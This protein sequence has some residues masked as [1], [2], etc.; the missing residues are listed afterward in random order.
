MAAGG[1]VAQGR[2]LE[3]VELRA[4]QERKW[5]T[6]TVLQPGVA[7]VL[8]ARGV[9]DP[10][11]TEP[12]GVD[13]LWCFKLERCRT[14]ELWQQLRIDGS[15][16]LDL[17]RLRHGAAYEMPLSQ[18]HAYRVPVVGQGRPLALWL[19]DAMENRSAN[20]NSGAITVSL[21]EPAAPPAGAAASGLPASR[22]PAGPVA[23]AP[24]APAVPAT[25]V[26]VVSPRPAPA[27]TARPGPALAAAWVG[28]DRDEVGPGA[29]A[30][31]NGHADGHFRLELDPGN[32]VRTV[33]YMALHAVDADG[34]P[35]GAQVWDTTPNGYWILGV[36]SRDRRLNPRDGE[37]ADQVWSPVSYDLFA[38]NSG[39]FNP[40]QSFRLLVRFT[41]GGELTA[42]ARIPP[43]TAAV[44][45]Q[46]PA[47]PAMTSPAAVAAAPA[48]PPARLGLLFVGIDRDVVGPARQPVPNGQADG[49]FRITVDT[50]GLERTLNEI[51]LEA[52]DGGGQAWGS[53]P[54]G[55]SILAVERDGRRL[56]PSD[57]GIAERIRGRVAYDVYGSDAGSFRLGQ[58]FRVRVRFADGG[59]ATA[60]ARIGDA[61]T[62]GAHSVVAPAMLP[63][64][65]AVPSAAMAAAAPSPGGGPYRSRWDRIGGDWSSGWLGDREQQA[66]THSANCNCYG[67]DFC[68]E[69]RDGAVTFVWPEGCER[70]S[71]LIRCRV[72]PRP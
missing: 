44:A 5:T 46:R 8:E 47:G 32:A 16:L 59:E 39:W 45:V 34:N 70:P 24:V 62:G 27:A 6:A 14:P 7:Y 15:G 67:Q 17:A 68:G 30:T 21:H 37:I 25:P 29:E 69:H 36:Q 41:D 66:C 1:A 11:G 43:A 57:T 18:T 12:K 40:G 50:Q 51:S 4:D 38:N 58:S 20:G 48:S 26:A 65:A 56:N 2:L 22:A 33:S 9:F 63:G 61:A 35:V 72:E 71:W 31:P 52:G 28:L 49:R 53:A 13:A 19:W 60:T 23:V 10:W 3:T 54:G 42:D 64:L 55:G